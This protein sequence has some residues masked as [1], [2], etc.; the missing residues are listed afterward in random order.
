[1]VL[2]KKYPN[3]K[4]YD[5]E[6]RSYVNYS[7]VKKILVRGDRVK[8]VRSDSGQDITKGSL[9]TMML[10]ELRKDLEKLSVNELTYQLQKSK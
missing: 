9:V 7:H 8:I 10:M 3:R 2:I 6:E 5:K 1:M 4:L